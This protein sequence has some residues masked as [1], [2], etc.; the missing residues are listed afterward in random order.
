MTEFRCNECK[1]DFSGQQ[2]LD[3]HNRNK[4][5][6][7]PNVPVSKK[8]N[9]KYVWIFLAIALVV[10]GV[11]FFP[12]SDVEPGYYDEFANCV[13]DSGAIFY[14]A[15]WCPHCSEQKKAFADSVGLI[16]YVECSLPNNAGQTE[17]C[18]EAGIQSYPTWEFGDES[19][20]SGFIPLVNLAE[21]TGCVLPE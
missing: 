5:Y 19:R 8:V 13:T 14:G 9:K 11:Y 12:G 7:T 4:H 18:K 2:G 20:Q 17:V 10:V 21:K 16:N 1:K 3:D 15:Y 6:V